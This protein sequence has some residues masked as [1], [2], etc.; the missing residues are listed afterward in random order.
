MRKQKQPLKQQ[1]QDNTEDY[2]VFH[3]VKRH[4]WKQLCR[5]HPL[6]G[7][8]SRIKNFDVERHKGY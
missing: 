6:F 4:L 8:E 1:R 5:S 3:A 2:M 7:A